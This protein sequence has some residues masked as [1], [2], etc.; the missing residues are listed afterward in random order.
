[1]SKITA[2]EMREIAVGEGDILKKR[3]KAALVEMKKA[4]KAGR[5]STVISIDALTFWS[6]A[7]APPPTL[8]QTLFML[9]LQELGYSVKVEQWKDHACWRRTFAP[10]LFRFAIV[11][12]W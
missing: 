12:S 11:A 5:M 8:I 9:E 10:D 1:M 7:P 6:D 3:V 4:A 2:S